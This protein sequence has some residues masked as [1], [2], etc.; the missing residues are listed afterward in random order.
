MLKRMHERRLAGYRSIGYKV[1][2][3]KAKEKGDR[4]I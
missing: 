4:R 2:G 1:G 3:T